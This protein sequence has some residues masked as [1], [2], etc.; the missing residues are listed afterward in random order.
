VS[1]TC[2]PES[3]PLWSNCPPVWGCVSGSYFK[4]EKSESSL[5]PSL[6][7]RLSLSLSLSL[8][9][10]KFPLS[11]ALRGRTASQPPEAQ[12]G[13]PGPQAPPSPPSRGGASHGGTTGTAG[14]LRAA[15][16]PARHH[17][18]VA[19]HPSH[20]MPAESAR[21][22]RGRLGGHGLLEGVAL[23]CEK[24]RKFKFSSARMAAAAN[25][26]LTGRHIFCPSRRR[27]TRLG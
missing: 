8:S 12:P 25:A 5:S 22:A 23:A 20:G 24:I 4:I 13:F 19:G 1:R 21:G 2:V 3:P 14:R 26:S 17:G 11:R 15:S 16:G 7:V 9:S 6:S 27:Q 18:P 10:F